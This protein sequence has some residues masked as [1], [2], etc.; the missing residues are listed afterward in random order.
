[1]QSFKFLDIKN[2]YPNFEY[3]QNHIFFAKW[4]VINVK[5]AALK[6]TKKESYPNFEKRRKASKYVTYKCIS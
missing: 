5:F 4:K 2:N 6:L 3:S 1:M